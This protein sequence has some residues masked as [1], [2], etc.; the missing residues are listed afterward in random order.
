MNSYWY[1]GIVTILFGGLLIPFGYTIA[2]VIRFSRSSFRNAL[3]FP[4]GSFRAI[5]AYT[6]VAYLGFYILT[7]VLS[8]SEFKPP[9]FLL[10]IV[11]TVVGFYFGSKTGEDG[12]PDPSAGIVRGIVR[13]GTN[14]ARGAL[15]KFTR[16]D[17]SEPYSRITDLEGHFELRG[18]RAGKYK[19][20]AVLTGSSP[21]KP[22]DLN[23]TEGS[24]QEIEIVIPSQTST[25]PAQTA[26]IQGTVTKAADNSPV[27][28]A[29]V[30]LTQGG[31]EKGK[32]Q[33]DTA[34]KYKIEKVA[35]GDYEI[36]VSG[37]PGGSKPVK[38][39][40]VSPP[41]IDLQI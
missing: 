41:P 28:N 18:A 14:P 12:T 40:A 3:G 6:L 27:G 7:S 23:I 17:G 33:T 25:T 24:D 1:Y 21:S 31:V 19:V 39:A 35:F 22:Q 37:A 36:A 4:V 8:V 2:R 5:L 13:I 32:A 16:E 11:A 29:T 10:G 20:I 15:V 30:V 34:G 38:V 9:E 26:T